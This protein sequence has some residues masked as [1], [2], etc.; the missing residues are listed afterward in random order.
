MFTRILSLGLIITIAA[1]IVSEEAVESMLKKHQFC[2]FVSVR[3]SFFIPPGR[4]GVVGHGRSGGL[5][6]P[7]AALL[8]RHRRHPDVF[9][10]RLAR[11]AREHPREVDAGSQTLLSQRSH[12]SRRK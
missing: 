10:H 5:R 12:H 7:P 2:F 1:L 11:L 6:S 4:A 9:Q 8:P 3:I